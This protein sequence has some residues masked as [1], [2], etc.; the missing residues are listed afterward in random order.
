MRYLSDADVARLLPPPLET[1]QLAHAALVALADGERR[2][3]GRSRLSTRVEPPSPTP[4]PRHTRRESCW[5]AS[6]SAS[7]PTTR[8]PGLPTV[9]GLMVVNDGDTGAAALRDGGRRPDRGPDRRRQRC[10]HRCAGRAGDAT[11]AITGAGV[12]ARSH[13]RVLAALGRHDVTVYARRPRPA[14]RWSPGPPS[15]VP[16]VRA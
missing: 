14:R 2:G 10:L 13:L 15:A 3:A 4:C 11:V 1:L 8:R 16:E 12:Q 7:S 5:A 9:P 6:G